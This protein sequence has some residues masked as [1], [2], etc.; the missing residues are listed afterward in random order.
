MELNDLLIAY[1]TECKFC[2]PFTNTSKQKQNHS[3]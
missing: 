2:L 1:F 3:G